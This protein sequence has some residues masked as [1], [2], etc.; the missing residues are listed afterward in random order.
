MKLLSVNVF[1]F[2]S[3]KRVSLLLNVPH[4]DANKSEIP[5]FQ[6]LLTFFLSKVPNELVNQQ[7]TG[8]LEYQTLN[9]ADNLS[10]ELSFSRS[11][12]LVSVSFDRG[13]SLEL[14]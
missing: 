2:L 7:D 3:H 4:H 13:Q 6:I 11:L 9:S 8:K 10:F 14:T 12:L 1:L 5:H